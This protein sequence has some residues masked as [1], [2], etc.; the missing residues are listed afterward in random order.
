MSVIVTLAVCAGWLDRVAFLSHQLSM[1]NNFDS[2]VPACV[3][4]IVNIALA[5]RQ[6][7]LTG[8]DDKLN[9]SLKLGELIQILPLLR[10]TC[11]LLVIRAQGDW[12]VQKL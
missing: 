9:S 1:S 6:E 7:R 8:T 12:P 11:L 5:P 4:W 3:Y 2:C 10:M